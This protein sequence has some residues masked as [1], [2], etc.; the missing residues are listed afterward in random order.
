MVVWITLGVLV[1]CGI[2]GWR[3]GVL[4]RLIELVGMLVAVI[5]TA[6]FASGMAPWLSERTPL[7][8]T[9]ALVA[10][11]VLMFAAALVVVRLVAKAVAAF[12]HWTPLGWVDRFGGAVCGALLGA[13]V[14]S[15]GLIA[16]SQAPGGE[17]VRGAYHE[18]PVGELIY[19]TAPTIYQAANE[20]FGGDV[21]EL[22]KRAVELGDDVADEA[23]KAADKV[24]DD[25]S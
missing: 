7:D 22:W 21:D 20:L 5:V 13:L 11:Y 23:R 2:F 15:V 4:K 12:V 6:R 25:G 1:I 9:A 14:V 17:K 8:D 3:A 24:T 16:V 10:G 19:H 18:H